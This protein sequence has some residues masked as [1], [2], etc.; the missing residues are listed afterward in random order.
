MTASNAC[1]SAC[2]EEDHVKEMTECIKLDR[3]CA[4]I[5]RV[6]ITSMQTH[7]PFMMEIC[8]LCA[9]VCEACAKECDKHPH[10]HCRKCAEACYRCANLCRNMSA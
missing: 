2:L 6:A 1:Y 3:E 4:D 10:D 5:C 7:S 9:D 8:K